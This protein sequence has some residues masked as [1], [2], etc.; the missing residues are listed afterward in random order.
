MKNSFLF[1]PF[2][3]FFTSQSY[4]LE[5]AKTLYPNALFD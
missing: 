2:L 5:P 1:L 4:A 3:V